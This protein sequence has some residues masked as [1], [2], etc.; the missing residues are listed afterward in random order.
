MSEG[1]DRFA[2]LGGDPAERRSAAERLAERDV[3]HPE[4]PEGPPEVPR[5]AGTKYGWVV[6]IV[7]LMI[8]G[9]LLYRSL[10]PESDSELL[11]L[12][13]GRPL[14]V[15]A[16]PLATGPLEGDAN[17]CERR[18]CAAA[19][20]PVPACD[21]RSDQVLNLCRLRR[22]PVVLTFVFDRGA[23]C[24]PQV[25]RTERMKD[26][27][28][29]VAFATVYFSRQ[30]RAEIRSVVRRRR[31]TQPAGVD[32]DGQVV[33]RYG[34]A[35]CPTTVFARAGG[36]VSETALGNL[37]EAELRAKTRRIAGSGT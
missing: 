28:P 29:R 9:L 22:R 3:T 13:P 19:A 23:D 4:E 12:K 6:G 7:V 24:F 17:V 20:G 26:E 2:D 11:G 31:W 35:G 14:P 15:F 33:N 16:A 37:T 1:D 18:P 32:R 36:S 21:V 25:D 27:F 34:V 8:L 5:R 30:D 10:L